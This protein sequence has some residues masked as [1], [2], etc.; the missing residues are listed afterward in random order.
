MLL[1]LCLTSF[2]LSFFFLKFIYYLALICFP[3]YFFLFPSFS[4]VR[5]NASDVHLHKLAEQ[6]EECRIWISVHKMETLKNIEAWDDQKKNKK[7]EDWWKYWGFGQRWISLRFG[8]VCLVWNSCWWVKKA[9]SLRRGD[10]RAIWTHTGVGLD[11]DKH[12]KTD[13]KRKEAKK[14]REAEAE[15][16]WVWALKKRKKKDF[17]LW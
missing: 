13:T 2:K 6:L 11:L 10:Q 7:E 8:T 1:S 3:Y 16:V 12:G 5:S 4:R 15:S 9:R 17:G 14:K